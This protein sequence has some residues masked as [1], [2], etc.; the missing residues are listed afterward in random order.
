MQDTEKITVREAAKRLHKSEQFIR[1]G[2]QRGI[3]PIG[4][5]MQISTKRWTYYIS[6]VK[7]QELTGGI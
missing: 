4:Y 5:A 1:I 6:P 7:I 3:L 2:M